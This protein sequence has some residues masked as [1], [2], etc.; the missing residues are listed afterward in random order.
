M[1]FASYSVRETSGVNF[2]VRHDLQIFDD[3]LFLRVTVRGIFSLENFR[4]LAN[5]LVVEVVPN[6]ER[7]V[8]QFPKIHQHPE[9][10]IIALRSNERSSGKLNI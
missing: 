3:Q 5:F 9:S 10:K 1:Q 8:G 4:Q 2:K 7:V 6:E